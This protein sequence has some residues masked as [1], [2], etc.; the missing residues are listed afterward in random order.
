MPPAIG[1]PDVLP[2]V[3]ARFQDDSASEEENDNEGGEATGSDAT[4]DTNC[5]GKSK[6]RS[7]YAL[8]LL[9]VS[10]A[11]RAFWKTVINWCDGSNPV[12]TLTR[13]A[14]APYCAAW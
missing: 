10:M 4:K 8:V 14:S 13:F 2:M 6:A 7:N 5:C 3:G 9:S 1:M 12:L 11:L